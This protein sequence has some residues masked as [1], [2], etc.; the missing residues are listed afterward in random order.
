[1][2]P[3]QISSEE[4]I[5]HSLSFNDYNARLFQWNGGLYRGIHPQVSELYR[6]LFERGIVGSLVGKKLLIETEITALAIAN[7]ELVLQ[8]RQLPFVSYPW[9]WCDLMLQDAALLHL[10]LCL[11]LDNYDLTTGDAH[12]LNILFD[13]C[14]PI[15]ID[16][17][18]IQNHSA[19]SY[20]LWI[21]YE[22]FCHFFLNPLRLMAGGKGRIARWLLHDYERGVL[23]DDLEAL[24]IYRRSHLNLVKSGILKA[25]SWIKQ[26]IFRSIVS[27]FPHS[28]DFVKSKNNLPSRSATRSEFLANIRQVILD[29]DLTANNNQP[30]LTIDWSG[31]RALDDFSQRRE[32]VT[33]ILSQLQPTSVLEI[34]NYHPQPLATVAASQGSK[35]V[36]LTPEEHRARELYL[37]TR[38]KQLYILPLLFDLTSP[39]CDLANRWFTP[40]SDRLN[41]DLVLALDLVDRLVFKQYLTFDTIV[42]RLA[43]FCDR[44][45]LVEFI[46]REYP[47]RIKWSEDLASRFTWYCLDNFIASLKSQFEKVEIVANISDTRVLLLCEK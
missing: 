22:Q 26:Q 28:L 40:A 20:W 46:T 27:K 19:D 44:W 16:F 23:N 36:F 8:H 11:E 12:P 7:Y 1:M 17:G 41:C 43:I 45:L 6:D 31:D 35:V 29:I 5:A 13:G 30:D 18:S 37:D 3:R 34:D 2:H 39:S 38:T 32:K 24:T 4:S 47:Y 14:R 15:F 10:D 9:E 25:K 42:E 21:A 33:A